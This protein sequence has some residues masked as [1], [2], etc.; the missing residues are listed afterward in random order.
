MELE[1]SLPHSQA[2]ATCP[3]SESHQ[4]SPCPSIP[5][6][7][8]PLY[9]Y[10]PIYAV[11]FQMVISLRFPHQNPLSTSLLP[12]AWLHAPSPHSSRFDHLN[13]IWW[14][15]TGMLKPMDKNGTNA[16]FWGTFPNLLHVHFVTNTIQK[17]RFKRQHSPSWSVQLL[18]FYRIGSFVRPRCTSLHDMATFPIAHSCSRQEWRISTSKS[19]RPCLKAFRTEFHIKKKKYKAIL[20]FSTARVSAYKRGRSWRWNWA[21]ICSKHPPLRVSFLRPCIPLNIAAVLSLVTQ[22]ILHILAQLPTRQTLKKINMHVCFN[23]WGF[24]A[25]PKRIA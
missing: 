14:D 7:E 16:P 10:P 13:K 15:H 25:L 18:A 8:D 3:Y 2:P 23:C 21:G 22:F 9:Y 4:S 6:P 5:L 12:H 11:V 24:T 17:S 20:F 19:P 1:G